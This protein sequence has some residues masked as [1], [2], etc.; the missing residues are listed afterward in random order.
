MCDSDKEKPFQP[1]QAICCAYM[2]DYNGLI[3][4]KQLIR[5]MAQI[6]FLYSSH[7]MERNGC[8]HAICVEQQTFSDRESLIC[9]HHNVKYTALS[10]VVIADRANKLTEND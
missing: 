1:F 7:Q 2:Q 9:V 8:N 10:K 4:T 3:V 6:F 5:A